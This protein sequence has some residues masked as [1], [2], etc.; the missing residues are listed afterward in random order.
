MI[1]HYHYTFVERN[2]LTY[3]NW[4]NILFQYLKN[5]YSFILTLLN[6]N[7]N[8]NYSSSKQHQRITILPLAVLFLVMRIEEIIQQCVDSPGRVL[9]KIAME[10]ER[11]LVLFFSLIHYIYN[12]RVKHPLRITKESCC[13]CLFSHFTRV[14]GINYTRY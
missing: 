3:G 10:T 4:T 1:N 2:C 14:N 6:G 11:V 7:N 8:R 5:E 13:K 9:G 12:W